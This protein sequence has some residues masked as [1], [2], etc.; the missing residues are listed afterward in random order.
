MLFLRIDMPLIIAGIKTDARCLAPLTQGEKL[1]SELTT[2]PM[3]YPRH[4][5]TLALTIAWFPDA[6][7][8][9]SYCRR[10]EAPEHRSGLDHQFGAANRVSDPKPSIAQ[11]VTDDPEKRRLLTDSGR[12]GLDAIKN[13]GEGLDEKRTMFAE[14]F[15]D[16]SHGM[17]KA[18]RNTLISVLEGP[19]DSSGLTALDRQQWKDQIQKD[20][21]RWLRLLDE[22]STASGQ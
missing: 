18:M 6:C 9:S 20:A 16:H 11:Y 13:N 3:Q 15:R 10:V 7:H 8:F 1:P 2:V 5:S 14:L 12:P 22:R 4:H 19:P 21:I 17:T